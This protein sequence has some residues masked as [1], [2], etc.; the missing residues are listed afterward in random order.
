MATGDSLTQRLADLE[1]E[2]AALKA[3]LCREKSAQAPGFEARGARLIREAEE[4]H[5]EVVAAWEKF[6]QGLGIHGQPVGI[7]KL[8][9]MMIA[10]GINPD[11]NAFSQEIIAMREE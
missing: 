3:E 5:A 6:L 9:E 7:K 11:D 4:S 1:E 10:D 8:R 2:V